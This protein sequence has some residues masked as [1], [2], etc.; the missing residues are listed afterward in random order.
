MV[1][2]TRTL[3]GIIPVMFARYE[4]WLVILAVLFIALE[5]IVPWRRDQRALRPQIG[6]DIFW[7]AFNGYILGAL[8]G[9]AFMGIESVLSRGLSFVCDC[10]PEHL[11]LIG[12]LSLPLQILVALIVADFLEW[13]VHNAFHRVDIL[14]RFHRVH[15]SIRQMDWIGN[16]RFHWLEILVYRIV[17]YLPLAVLGARWEAVLVVAVF[18]TAIGNLNHANLNVSFGPLRYVLNS[19]RMHIWHH[20]AERPGPGV[21]FGIVLSVWDWIFRTAD[22]PKGPGGPAILGFRRMDEVPMSLFR[23]FFL[24]FVDS[25]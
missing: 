11:R 1:K 15:H 16:Y 2:G 22:M 3:A 19:P 24:P 20:D 18:A 14:W 21:N 25:R 7:F 6:Q 4:I 5:R 9:G 10:V 8:F 12:H 23:R 13:L 17:K